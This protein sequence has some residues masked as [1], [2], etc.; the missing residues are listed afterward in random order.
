MS[1][2]G[3][4]LGRDKLE[5]ALT[6]LTKYRKGNAYRYTWLCSANTVHNRKRHRS[7]I[8]HKIVVSGGRGGAT[9]L[10]VGGTNSASG[11]SGKF[12]F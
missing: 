2:V 12:F 7:E 9:V 10:K 11:A 6:G 3:A 4:N 1:R 5:R 8:L